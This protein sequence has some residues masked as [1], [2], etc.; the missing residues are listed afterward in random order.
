MASRKTAQ[1]KDFLFWGKR[2]FLHKKWRHNQRKVIALN[3]YIG[4]NVLVYERSLVL[5]VRYTAGQLAGRQ[6]QRFCHSI[7]SHCSCM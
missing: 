3:M 5:K 4:T 2:Q 6:A 7:D 1:D